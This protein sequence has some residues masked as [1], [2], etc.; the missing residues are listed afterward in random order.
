MVDWLYSVC[1]EVS[2]Q[3]LPGGG[4]YRSGCD[5]RENP[6]AHTIQLLGCYASVWM[7]LLTVQGP[8]CGVFERQRTESLRRCNA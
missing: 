4:G 2:S 8:R 1:L 5:T 7:C 6:A 3:G